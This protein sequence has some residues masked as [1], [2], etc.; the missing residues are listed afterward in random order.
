MKTFYWLNCVL[1]T[2]SQSLSRIIPSS[3][4]RHYTLCL[5]L[6]A[7]VCGVSLLGIAASHLVQLFF[8]HTPLFS[9]LHHLSSVPFENPWP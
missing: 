8:L 1:T 3:A 2:I 7:V 6:F 5:L 9:A 4:I